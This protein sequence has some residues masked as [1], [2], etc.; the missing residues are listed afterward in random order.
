[1]NKK[2]K[3][4]KEQFKISSKYVGWGRKPSG[5]KAI[6]LAKEHHSSFLLL[7]D[8]FIRSIGLGVENW[9]SFSVVE[10]DIGIY[11]D[12]TAP[13]RLENILQKHN[14]AQEELSLAKEAIQLIKKYKISKYNN[15]SLKLP[16]FLETDSKKILIIAQTKGD[17]SL[18]Y[19][20]ATQF[21]SKQMI[22]D[23]IKENPNAEIFLKIHPDVLSGK[24]ESNIDIDFA[25]QHC[26]VITQNINP[27]VLLEKFEKVYTQT[28][29]MGFE[30]LLL[31]KDVYLYGAPFYAGWGLTNDKVQVQRR[32]RNITLEEIFAGAYILYTKYYNPYAQKETNIID[33]IKTI[34]SYRTIYERNN[35]DL[36]FFN[37]S[38]WK[39]E[40]IKPFFK[41]STKNKILFC[42]SLKDAKT[43]GLSPNAKIFIWGRKGF[44]DIKEYARVNGNSLF[45][46]EDG[47][48][49]SVSLGSDLTQPYS[50]VVD[51]HGIYFDPTKESDLEK[52]LN[53]YEFSKEL[54]QRA[55][56]LQDYII[57]NKF[58]K[59]NLY[60]NITI[61]L[62]GYTKGQT[63]IMCP[64]QV[65]D[66][67]SIIYGGN[68]M[69]NLELLQATR[70]NKPD[71]YIIY[72]PHPDV[73][74]GNRKGGVEQ[75]EALQ[76]CNLIV[77]KASIDSVLSIVDE[78]HTITSLVGFESLLRG[79]KVYTYGIPFYAGWG[80]TID[81][82]EI[83]RRVKKH[84]LESLIAATF[85]L[86]PRYMNPQTKEFCEVEV[87]LKELEK[88]REKYN[89]N[90]FYRVFLL[91]RNFFS[92]KIQLL[93]K[94]I[95]NKD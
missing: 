50:L 26:T 27:I 23:A 87:L 6:S 15:S 29:Q 19:G 78:V 56:K 79:K 43:K 54:L 67:A 89:N 51:K 75:E 25:K 35:G 95:L 76:Y 37:F 82:K 73:L 32:T 40:F 59:Y 69:S 4:I 94:F 53:N 84:S 74:A 61:D 90:R 80:L 46:V 21:D 9:E 38:L 13:S 70:K 16:K 18:K 83:T 41:P 7:E 14:F 57:K 2:I 36:Y 92:R 1:M 91:S 44:E 64:G 28:S 49:R 22:Q 52:I 63:I 48:I 58:S 12:A 86:Y 31:D 17:L 60:K 39:R 33:T 3:K 72:K 8:G 10:D 77:E 68:K 24:K 5:L 55:S 71:A 81:V 66:D 62:E 34:V 45:H 11:Y 42:S 93:L 20:L 47:F 65:E 88:E 30:A 85:I